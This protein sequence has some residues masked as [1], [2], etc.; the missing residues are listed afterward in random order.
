LSFHF[1]LV[2]LAFPGAIS[3]SCSIFPDQATLPTAAAGSAGSATVA[4]GGHGGDGTDMMPFAGAGAEGG[5]PDGGA[6][7]AGMAGANALGGE[8]GAPA[9]ANSRTLL[10]FPNADTWIES[11]KPGTGH[12]MDTMLSVVS[13]INGIEGM[14][15]RRALLDLTLPAVS[16]KEVVV[17]ATLTLHLQANADETLAARELHAHRLARGVVEA[18]AT[19]TS[20]DGPTNKWQ[21]LGGDFDAAFAEA[22][23]PAGSSEGALVFDVTAV[24]REAFAAKAASVPFVVLESGAPPPAPA[25]LSLVSRQGLVSGIPALIVELCPP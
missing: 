5:M 16:S 25:Q 12:G 20:W 14:D 21:T 17:K 19:W 4:A 23:V 18:R 11:A 24:V 8:G 22:S 6:P 15:E 2:G 10:G 3:F 13:G 7:Q 9:C 1:C